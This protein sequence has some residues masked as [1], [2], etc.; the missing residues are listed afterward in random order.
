MTAR[1]PPVEN[2]V[3]H[4]Q[5]RLMRMTKDR[6]DPLLDRLLVPF[7]VF[8]P[9]GPYGPPVATKRMRKLMAKRLEAWKR[10]RA[11]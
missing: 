1:L 9:R 7:G 10:E 8:L 3:D 5:Y 11:A 4:L 6:R 2:E